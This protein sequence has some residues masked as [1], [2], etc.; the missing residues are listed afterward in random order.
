MTY[1]YIYLARKL[2]ISITHSLYKDFFGVHLSL[3]KDNISV[4]FD[5]CSVSTQV[6]RDGNPYIR[7]K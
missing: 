5:S 3:Y 1:I 6:R 7:T 2:G 4:Y